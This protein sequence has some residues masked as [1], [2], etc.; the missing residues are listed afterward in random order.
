[1][2]RFLALGALGLSI[3]GCAAPR[4]TFTLSAG[5]NQQS[6]IR[7]GVPALVSTKR[8]VVF[9]RPAEDLQNSFERPRFVVAMFNRGKN[10]ATMQVS[11]IDVRSTRP[12]VARLRVYTYAELMAEVETKK[13]TALVL[14]ALAG[15]AGAYSAAQAGQVQTTGSFTR[16]GP[17]GASYGTY[18]ATTY[19]PALAQIAMNQNA[20]RTAYDMASIQAQAQGKLQELQ[21]TILKDHTVMPGEW[22]GGVIVFDDPPKSTAGAA[23]YQIT[24]RFD[25]EEHVFNVAQRRRS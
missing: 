19:N 13:N 6:V 17:Y 5:E 22:H 14:T 11:D 24:V 21:G 16:Q 18:S 7:D 3:V 2:I 20:D 1:M 10:P 9:L 23:E 15:A 4:D 8:N 12:Q 25:G